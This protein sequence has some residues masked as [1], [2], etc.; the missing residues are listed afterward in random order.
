MRQTAAG[1]KLYSFMRYFWNFFIS[2]I[3]PQINRLKLFFFV[4][5]EI[6]D[7][8][9]EACTDKIDAGKTPRRVSLSGVTYFANISEESNF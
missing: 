3:K 8:C 9:G 2:L 5:A 1:F 7:I 4:F 6:F